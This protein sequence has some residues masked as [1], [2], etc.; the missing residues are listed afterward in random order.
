MNNK[1]RTL[2]FTFPIRINTML[3]YDVKIAADACLE[4]GSYLKA[5]SY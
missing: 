2:H 1:Q 5:S 3:Q 4:A